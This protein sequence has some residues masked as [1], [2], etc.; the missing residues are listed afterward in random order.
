M[1][2]VPPITASLVS[3]LITQ[4]FPEYRHLPIQAVEPGGNDNRTFRLGDTLSVRLPS[5]AGYATQVQKEQ[6]WLPK[7]APHISI[8]IPKP[9]AMGKPS[10]LYPWH[11]SIYH[12]I[13]GETV[14]ITNKRHLS[15]LAKDFVQFLTELHTI[16]PTDGPMGGPHNY[17]RGAPLSTYDKDTRFYIEE[18]KDIIDSKRTLELWE[19]A[20]VSRW[21]GKPVWVHGDMAKGNFLIQNRTLS[22]V[23]DFGCIGI[24]DPACDLVIAWTILDKESRSIF[25]KSLPLD[26]QTW[27]R[28]K[29]WALWKALFELYS[30]QDKSSPKAIE[31]IQLIQTILA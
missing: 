19:E 12:W 30:C 15:S 4:Q 8:Q 7:L 31:N 25:Q 21:R 6:D 14:E 16:D 13:D 20:I 22:A 5:A 29:G 9:I 2:K 10:D 24:G 26:P 23:I 27:S 1:T 11:W 3:D 28:A 18:L 17:Y